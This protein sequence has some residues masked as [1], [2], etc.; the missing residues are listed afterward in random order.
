MGC[1][2]YSQTIES[3]TSLK[4]SVY[5]LHILIVGF[6]EISDKFVGCVPDYWVEYRK[7][8]YIYVIDNFEP[9]YSLDSD[10]NCCICEE[11]YISISTQPL[12]CVYMPKCLNYVKDGENYLCSECMEEY[13]LNVKGECLEC[14]EG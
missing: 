6:K 8:G 9:G 1:I 11:D 10:G 5:A 12:V 13:Q 3:S 4:T 14:K 2:T 7:K